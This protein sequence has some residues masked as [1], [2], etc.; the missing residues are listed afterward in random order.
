MLLFQKAD[1]IWLLWS[2]PIARHISPWAPHGPA[3]QFGRVNLSL[4]SLEPA[5]KKPEWSA[6]GKYKI[7]AEADKKQIW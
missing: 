3:R 5:R 7:E 2:S 6:C 1:L 4:Y